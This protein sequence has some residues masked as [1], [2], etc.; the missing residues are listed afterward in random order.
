MKLLRFIARLRSVDTGG[1]KG[2]DVRSKNA[3]VL[4]RLWAKRTA[5]LSIV[6]LCGL[7]L[8]AI[9]APHVSEY[10][11]DVMDIPNRFQ[12]PS[13]RHLFGTDEFGRDLL[14]RIA[15]GARYTLQIGMISVTIS[16]SMGSLLGLMSG[17]FGGWADMIIMRFIELMLAFPGLLLSLMVIA[18]LGPGLQNAM[19][20]VGIGS[21]PDFARL[22]RGSVLSIKEKEYIEAARA[23]GIRQASI[24]FRHI[25]PNT[26]SPV[27]VLAT[28]RLP[29]AILSAA[30]LSFIGLGAQP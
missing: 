27:I 23:G 12:P 5:K 10:E 22:V 29:G 9:F 8:T 13:R 2:E 6:I 11:Y 17:F 20:A 16:V 19:I 21:M 1:L 3:G 15:Y 24:L 26:V 18:V 4:K 30:A 14:S 7:V 25:L 28:M